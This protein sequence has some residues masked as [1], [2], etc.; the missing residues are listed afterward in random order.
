MKPSSLSLTIVLVLILLGSGSYVWAQDLQG[1]V[2]QFSV[3]RP[4]NPPVIRRVGSKN[5]KVE[6]SKQTSS[7]ASRVAPNDEAS[8]PYTQPRAGIQD[9]VEDALYLGNSARDAKPP[10]YKEAERAYRLAAKLSPKDPRPYVGLGNIF[11]DQG[12]YYEAAE[13]YKE[14]LRLAD[15]LSSEEQSHLEI[16]V[17]TGTAATTFNSDA[18]KRVSNADEFSNITT[19]HVYLG[20]ALLYKKKWS[21]AEAELRKAIKQNPSNAQW[22]ALLG[23]ALL[24]QQKYDD[25]THAFLSAVTM[26]KKNAVYWRLFDLSRKKQ[27]KTKHSW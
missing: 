12:K 19:W 11:Y 27:E 24:K 5:N 13:A 3:K 6:E 9:G 17:F 10:R 4:K 21:E 7:I 22:Y 20:N 26:D 18:A 1:G 2:G 25:A 23:W 16:G 15:L 8:A 14:A